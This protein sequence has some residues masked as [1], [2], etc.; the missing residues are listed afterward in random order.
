MGTIIFVVPHMDL[1]LI[2][3][4]RHNPCDGVL[5]VF[6]DNGQVDVGR[7]TGRQ[8]GPRQNLYC[9]AIAEFVTL[10]L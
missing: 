1:P 10:L 8:P 7:A 4:C 5:A 6:E 3:A 2:G 9:H